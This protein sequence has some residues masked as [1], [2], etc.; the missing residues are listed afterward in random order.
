MAFAEPRRPL[1]VALLGVC[2]V[3]VEWRFVVRDR[4]EFHVE[5]D[6]AWRDGGMAGWRPMVPACDSSA[7]LRSVAYRFRV[8]NGEIE[9]GA[10]EI[11]AV[12]RSVARDLVAM[13]SRSHWFGLA[14][15]GAG[16]GIGGFGAALLFGVPAG[17]SQPLAT[18]LAGAGALSAGVLAYVNGERSRAL[19]DAQHKTDAARERER[20]R[21]DSDRERECS[22]R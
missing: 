1:L 17:F 15:A 19:S 21:E 7:Q 22:L 18:F 2:L 3:A 10:P 11:G 14:L 5:L 6:A 20:H 8:A 16:G 9:V 4:Y 12:H 13:L